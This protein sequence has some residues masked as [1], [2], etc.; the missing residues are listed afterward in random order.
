[1]PSKNLGHIPI[2]GRS[3]Q[4]CN[5]FVLSSLKVNLVEG[6]VGLSALHN[7][8]MFFHGYP[9]GAEAGSQDQAQSSVPELMLRDMLPSCPLQWH[10]FVGWF[11]CAVFSTTTCLTS[12]SPFSCPDAVT[13]VSMVENLVPQHPGYVST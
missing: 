5:L 7:L 13:V 8:A 1:M 11:A 2:C 4:R 12:A 9:D 10:P 3:A 6:G